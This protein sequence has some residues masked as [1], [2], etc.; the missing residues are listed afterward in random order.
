MAGLGYCRYK[1]Y[2]DWRLDNPLID[3]RALFWLVR[4]FGFDG[5]LHW[6][7]NQWGGDSSL[8]PVSTMTDGFIHPADWNMATSPGSW[9]Q[10]GDTRIVCVC[11]MLASVQSAISAES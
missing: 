5:L 1:P 2:Q 3:S 6:G 8:Q 11:S 4:A 7:L 9:M 10:V